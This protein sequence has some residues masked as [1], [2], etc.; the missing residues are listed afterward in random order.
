M[1][2]Q[3]QEPTEAE[4]AYE[5]GRLKSELQFYKNKSAIGQKIIDGVRNYPKADAGLFKWLD[6]HEEMLNK[7]FI[8]NPD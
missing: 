3:K 2:K 6:A 8:Y 1:A 5:L 7:E 4:K